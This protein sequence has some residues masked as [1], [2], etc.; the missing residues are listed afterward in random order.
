MLGAIIG[1]LESGLKVWGLKEQRKYSDK[2][3]EIK[4]AYYEESNKPEAIRSDA[5]LDNLKFEL[6]NLAEGIATE[7]RT[8]NA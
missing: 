4:A 3:M 7:L 2:L 8:A 1:I 6:C 5:V